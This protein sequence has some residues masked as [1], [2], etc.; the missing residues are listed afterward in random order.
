MSKTMTAQ[1]AIDR[2]IQDFGA[3]CVFMLFGV[4]M[5]KAVES[6]KAG[7]AFMYTAKKFDQYTTE[8]V[9]PQVMAVAGSVIAGR[10]VTLEEIDGH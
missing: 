10:Q 4:G 1:Q 6:D 7:A 3:E 9:D 5:L 8:N 2:A